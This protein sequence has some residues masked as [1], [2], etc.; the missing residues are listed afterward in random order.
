MHE[1]LETIAGA[2]AS[3]RRVLNTPLAGPLWHGLYVR[4]EVSDAFRRVD[5]SSGEVWERLLALF[6]HLPRPDVMRFVA[7]RESLG[8]R[9]GFV[10][11]S[12][13]E[14]A[15]SVAEMRHYVNLAQVFRDPSTGNV[16]MRALHERYRIG[17]N[18][19]EVQH[20]LRK[21]AY[22][23]QLRRAGEALGATGAD[24]GLARQIGVD[25]FDCYEYLMRNDDVG[26]LMV[27][28]ASSSGV[29]DSK[30]WLKAL[31]LL[32]PQNADLLQKRWLLMESHIRPDVSAERAEEARVHNT[33]IF[34]TILEE[35]GLVGEELFE[36]FDMPHGKERGDLMERI[37]FAVL[38]HG[39]V[40]L[41]LGP[42]AN[43][44]IHARKI[45]T[46]HPE[47]EKLRDI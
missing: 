4:D 38:D 18:E 6:V 35:A 23:E 37:R 33:R 14:G 9:E 13:R 30:R 5:E 1:L 21:P 43:R 3:V 39:T 17:A 46:A 24:I 42:I 41:D 28:R 19:K 22:L 12:G 31:M 32:Y 44:I 16:D 15:M 2:D 8:E 36:R 25:V 40:P 27:M 10:M 26:Y 45:L 34:K 11:R 29:M 47:R 20:A 7:E